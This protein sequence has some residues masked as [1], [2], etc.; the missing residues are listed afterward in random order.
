[1]TATQNPTNPCA[2]SLAEAERWLGV[3]RQTLAKWV[4]RGAPVVK[5]AEGKGQSTLVSVPDLWK[6]KMEQEIEAAVAKARVEVDAQ[7]D[8]T[9]PERMSKE[10][11]DRR[12]AVARALREEKKALEEFKQ[13]ARIDDMAGAVARRLSTVR[14]ILMALYRE[15]PELLMRKTGI[16]VNVSTP[17][18]R[19]ILDRALKEMNARLDFGPP[20]NKDI[21]QTDADA[22]TQS[23]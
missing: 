12:L 5:R 10:E 19:G 18:L 7:F 6:W 17:I 8:P 15:A 13:I 16:A 2:C 14:Q 3:S 9:N 22:A 11:A 1:M 21:E 23:T 20:E 4:D